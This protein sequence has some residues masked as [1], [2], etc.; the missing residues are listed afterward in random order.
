MTKKEKDQISRGVYR[1]ADMTLKEI[2]DYKVKISTSSA[3]R[4]A[5]NFLYRACEE[6]LK[7][8]DDTA[9]AIAVNGDLDDIN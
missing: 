4:E 6:R 5:K 9:K 1:I 3:S 2:N 7:E 8:I